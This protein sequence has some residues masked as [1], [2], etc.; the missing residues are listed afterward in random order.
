[1]FICEGVCVHNHCVCINVNKLMSS[2]TKP[3]NLTLPMCY[4]CVYINIYYARVYMCG[5]VSL[6]VPNL[7]AKFPN[8]YIY[9]Y[10]YIYLLSPSQTQIHFLIEN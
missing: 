9:I 5:G 7:E 2:Q 3:K 10:I 1:M 4:V 8:H 6:E